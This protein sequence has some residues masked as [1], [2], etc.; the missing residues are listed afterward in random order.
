VPVELLTEDWR[1][2]F[3]RYLDAAADAHGRTTH[4]AIVPSPL[5][6]HLMAEWLV[7]RARE[8]WPS[9]AVETRPLERVPQLPWQRAGADNV[10]YVSYA[11]WTCPINCIEPRTCPHTRNARDWSLATSLPTFARDA[12]ESDRP[13]EEQ[14][15][16]VLHCRHRAYGVGMFDTGEVIAGDDTIRRLGESG[17]GEVL[18]GT[19]SHC[20]GAITRLVIGALLAA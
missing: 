18:I 10:H 7:R 6:P 1:H 8:R 20:H 16:I 2:F 3:A 15:A 19:V 11:D 9:R 12:T 17:P 14:A 4:D 13:S 5:M